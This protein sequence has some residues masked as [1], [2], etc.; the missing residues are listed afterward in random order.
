M[1]PA[2]R[3]DWSPKKRS[4]KI[5]LRKEGYSYRQI[6][7]KMGNGVSPGGVQNLC[8][9]FKTSGAITSKTGRGRKKATTAQTEKLSDLHCRIAETLQSTSTNHWMMPV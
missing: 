3:V 5:V 8:K 9:R 6:A 1:N 2:K 7:A 4:T